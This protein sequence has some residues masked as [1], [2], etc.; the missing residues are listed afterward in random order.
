MFLT[1]IYCATHETEDLQQQVQNLQW[2][3][4]DLEQQLETAERTLWGSV[5]CPIF[6][7]RKPQVQHSPVGFA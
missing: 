6:T 7:G 4:E 3:E 1:V 5:S 2:K